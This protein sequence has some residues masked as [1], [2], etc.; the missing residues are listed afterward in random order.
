MKTKK[1]R[2][3]EEIVAAESR[4]PDISD[5]RL[6]ADELPTKRWL[7]LAKTFMEEGNM[8]LALR[9]LYFASLSHLSHHELITLALFKSNRDYEREL[10]RK[11]YSKPELVGAFSQNMKIFERI[12][13]GM[14]EVTS[15]VVE[16]FNE[17]QER[18]ITFEETF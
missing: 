11:A 12:W 4:V 7:E 3:T 6:T 18:I 2:K 9:A 10:V 16:R 1:G 17:N 15:E 5:E 8:R 13:Y 14:H